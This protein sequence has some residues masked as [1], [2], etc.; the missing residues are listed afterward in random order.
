MA[1][2]PPTTTW[3]AEILA[4]DLL[5]YDWYSISV[6]YGDYI[7]IYERRRKWSF[8]QKFALTCPRDL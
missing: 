7:L 2:H 5:K 4:S 1:A 3:Q 6:A 8:R